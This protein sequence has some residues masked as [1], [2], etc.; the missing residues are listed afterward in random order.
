MRRGGVE[1][2]ATT[3]VAREALPQNVPAYLHRGGACLCLC[4][5]VPGGAVQRYSTAEVTR[6]SMW[7]G[8][9]R[10]LYTSRQ[11]LQVA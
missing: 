6:E 10:M 11:I 2:H 8:S 3:C 9:S 1:E 5:W 4:L 7:K